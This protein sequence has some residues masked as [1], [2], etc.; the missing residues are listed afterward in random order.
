MTRTTAT[1]LISTPCGTNPIERTQAL[2]PKVTR[3]TRIAR[4]RSRSRLFLLILLALLPMLG[5]VRSIEP[6]YSKEG[7]E[8]TLEPSLAGTWQSD[9]GKLLCVFEPVTGEGQALKGYRLHLT[10]LRTA[11]NKPSLKA[12]F[13]VGILRIGDRLY[14]DVMPMEI[15]DYEDTAPDA[16]RLLMMPTHTFLL[17]TKSEPDLVIQQPDGKTWVKTVKAIQATQP[18]DA[19]Q[20]PLPAKIDG[21][22]SIL[23]YASPEQLRAFLLSHGKDEGMFKDM[24]T[25]KKISPATQPAETQPAK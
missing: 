19:K 18:A 23:F 22:E 1:A 17:I 24:F 3:F 5:C 10:Q 8:L 25:L 21:E 14:A 2:T 20:N 4:F 11:E 9:D 16:W 12:M 7:T 15:P 13:G 6:L